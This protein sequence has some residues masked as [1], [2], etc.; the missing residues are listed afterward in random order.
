MSKTRAPYTPEFHRR[1]VELVHAGRSPDELAREF[2]P[3]AHRSGT[4]LPGRAIRLAALA[5][6][7]RCPPGSLGA[8]ARSG[9]QEWPRSRGRPK[10]LSL[11]AASTT[12][13]WC[14]S[15]GR[16]SILTPEPVELLALRRGQAVAGIKSTLYKRK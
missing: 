3:T 9:G 14:A 5:A 12:A 4:G 11:T 13:D 2:E 15:G 8:I 10:G 16:F 7:H 6:I 1:M